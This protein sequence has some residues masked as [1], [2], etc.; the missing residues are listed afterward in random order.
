MVK[1][2]ERAE[3]HFAS[4]EKC[5]G[6]ASIESFPENDGQVSFCTGTLNL[7]GI[8]YRPAFYWAAG[9]LHLALLPE[10][11]YVEYLFEKREPMPDDWPMTL[12]LDHD[13]RFRPTT[14][15]KIFFQRIE[16][17]SLIKLVD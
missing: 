2:C 11:L 4:G 6:V 10:N 13:E 17:T 12:M 1:T 14:T 7:N 15:R 5:L 8:V 16:V 3:V 9:I